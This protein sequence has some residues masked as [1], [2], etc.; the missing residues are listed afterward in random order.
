MGWDE[1]N[2]DMIIDSKEALPEQL[3]DYES[4]MV[5]IG[6]DVVSLYPNL[7]VDKVIVTIKEAISGSGVVWQEFDYI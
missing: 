6:S 4:K 7:E 1:S 5:I 3:Q 2:L